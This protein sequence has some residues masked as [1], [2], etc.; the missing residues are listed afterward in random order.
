MKTPWS[1]CDTTR[2]CDNSS[3]VAWRSHAGFCERP[4]AAA[5]D[6]IRTTVARADLDAVECAAET[7]DLAEPREMRRRA[8]PV[9][10]TDRR[11]TSI[12]RPSW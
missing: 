7:H 2:S 12:R 9:A 6:D 8:S 10:S 11:F 5:I 3:L 1:S 4:R